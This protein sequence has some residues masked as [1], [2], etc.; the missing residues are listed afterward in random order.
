MTYQ[1]RLIDVAAHVGTLTAVA[2]YLR[3]EIIAIFC[4]LFAFGAAIQP[5]LALAY[6]VMRWLQFQ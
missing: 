1:G 5:T 4:A 6:W 3:V 2:I